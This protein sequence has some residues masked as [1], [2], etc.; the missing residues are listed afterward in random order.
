MHVTHNTF[1]YYRQHDS[2]IT[3]GMK[4]WNIPV[5]PLQCKRWKGCNDGK[6]MRANLETKEPVDE[7]V[8]YDRQQQ[9][10]LYRNSFSATG[11]Q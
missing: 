11:V 3:Q 9:Q 10:T 1:F 4:D 7:N 8:V 5:L 6:V 2:Y